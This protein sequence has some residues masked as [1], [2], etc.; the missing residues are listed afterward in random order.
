VA[1]E[2]LVWMTAECR[3]ALAG[4]EGYAC[5]KK[6]DT[7]VLLAC[8]AAGILKG[9][10]ADVFK[11]ERVCS[12]SVWYMKWQY[13]ED[14]AHALEVCTAAAQTW[15]DEETALAEAFAT[16]QIQR[17]IAE[18]ADV[19]VESLQRIERDKSARP[20][21]RLEAIRMHIA[22]LNPELAARLNAIEGKAALPVDVQGMPAIIMDAPPAKDDKDAE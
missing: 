13:L 10:K 21:D 11:D 22:L 20:G 19:P 2:G 4:I 5:R 1:D 9:P 17:A 12:E 6:R 7:V 8:Q 18:S 15:M 3:E 16:R 14:V